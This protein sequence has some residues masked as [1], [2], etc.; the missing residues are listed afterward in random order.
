MS[1]YL[2]QIVE[3]VTVEDPKGKLNYLKV[4]AQQAAEEAAAE[5]TATEDTAATVDTAATESTAAAGE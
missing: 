1:E 4:E 3:N 2:D 5:D